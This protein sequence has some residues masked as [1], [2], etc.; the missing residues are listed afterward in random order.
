MR[1]ERPRSWKLDPAISRELEFEGVSAT[2]PALCGYHAGEDDTDEGTTAFKQ[3]SIPVERH[4]DKPDDSDT[5]AK[6]RLP[7]SAFTMAVVTMLGVVHAGFDMD[8]EI[9][10]RDMEI[11]FS[12][13]LAV[14]ASGSNLQVRR[15]I[16]FHS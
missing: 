1:L 12:A 11:E 5:S 3:C 4:R 8:V 7:S 2:D 14:R 16:P 10:K 9:E 6:M 13:P 15:P